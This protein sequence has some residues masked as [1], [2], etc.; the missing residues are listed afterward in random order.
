[1]GE[2]PAGV[3]EAVGARG[4]LK[5]PDDLTRVVDAEGDRIER[6][7][8]ID[9]GEAPAGVEEAVDAVR[10]I[11]KIPD[12]LTRVV[13][14]EGLR[15]VECAG[16]IELGEAESRGIRGRAGGERGRGERGGYGENDP[17]GM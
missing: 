16:R 15:N 17:T 2:A 13:D 6:A 5:I 3:E 4:I 9:W 10:G 11:F 14:A 8:H 7:R 1:L 12:D